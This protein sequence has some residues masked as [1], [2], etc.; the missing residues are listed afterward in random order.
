MSVFGASFATGPRVEPA[1]DPL[2]SRPT[3]RTGARRSPMPGPAPAVRRE[4][5]PADLKILAEGLAYPE[6]PIALD[7]GSVLLVEVRGAALK[8]VRPDGRQS[9]IATLGGGPNGAALGPDGAV[10]ICN[11]GGFPWTRLPD[12]SWDL[13]DPATGSRAPAGFTGGWIERVDL[14]TGRVDRLYDTVDG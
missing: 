9:V 3:P 12:G 5:I 13:T 8:R 14:A 11:N 4:P 7:D 2:Q 6:G 1:P 10:Y